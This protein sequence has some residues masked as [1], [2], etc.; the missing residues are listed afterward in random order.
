MLLR[1]LMPADAAEYRRLRLSALREAPTAFGRS[2]AEE[3]LHDLSFFAARL[4]NT[5]DQWTV[6]AFS[7]RRLVGIISLVRD[8]P[9]KAHHKATLWGMYVAP[10]WRQRSI[11]RELI[12]HIIAI[13]RTLDGLKVLRLGVVSANRPAVKLYTACGFRTYGE[14]PLAL[15]VDGKYYAEKLMAL[16]LTRAIRRPRAPAR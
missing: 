4:E 5:A 9:L 2:Y 1:R 6:G 14:E 11:G 16:V 7:G 3:S 13:A 10:R 15:C 8:Q 12:E